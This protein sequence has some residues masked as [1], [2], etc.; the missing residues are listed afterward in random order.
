MKKIII[1]TQY[2]LPEMGAPQN[3]LYD[4]AKGLMKLGWE[5]NVVTAMPNYPTGKIFKSHQ[6]KFNQTEWIDDIEVRRYW[7]YPSNSP[8]VFPRILSMLSFTITSLFSLFYIRSK[9]PTYLLVE[10]PPL[11]LAFSGWIL[12]RLSPAKMILNVSDLWPL[13]AK[14][15]GVIRN[16]LMYSMLERLE[17]FL[18]RKAFLCTGQS[19]EIVDYILRVAPNSTFLFRNGVDA[20]RFEESR[21][22]AT[23]R[24][25]IVYGGLLGVAQGIFSIC[26]HIDFKKLNVEFH[27]YGTGA[28]Q[29]RIVSFLEE[30]P[31]R[32][33]VYHGTLNRNEMPRILSSYGGALIPLVK[34][35]YGA[36]PSKIYEAMAAGLPI[37]FSGEGE[38]AA[39]IKRIGGG[40]VSQPGNWDGL[41]KSIE[42]FRK[43]DDKEYHA[44]RE[45]NRNASQQFDRNH[46]ILALNNFI[47]SRIN[48]SW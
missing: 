20:S 25:K 34:N 36:V 23:K 48:K 47:S 38:G 37:I 1:L 24:N 46:Q 42:G 26:E 43:L 39:I 15:L 35:I 29:E 22:D 30:N 14:E 27:I 40:W 5:V 33:I 12:T 44:L 18:Y 21:F 4:M 11:A 19:Q 13:S 8:N 3:R 28:E 6:K 7:L 45:N 32:G 2:F 9:K 31:D 41:K 16:G 17:R 10:S